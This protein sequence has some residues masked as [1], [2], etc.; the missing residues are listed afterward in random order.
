MEIQS[1]LY[2]KSINGSSGGLKMITDVIA[3]FVEKEMV[4]HQW[5]WISF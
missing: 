4:Q 5:E 2:L 1:I 3:H